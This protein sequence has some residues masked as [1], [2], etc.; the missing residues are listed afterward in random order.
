[1]TTRKTG[2]TEMKPIDSTES[3]WRKENRAAAADS[4]RAVQKAIILRQEKKQPENLRNTEGGKDL[5]IAVVRH[6]RSMLLRYCM[7][8]AHI[9]YFIWSAWFSLSLEHQRSFLI[10]I[11]ELLSSLTTK[12]LHMLYKNKYWWT[13]AVLFGSPLLWKL[14]GR[15]A[16]SFFDK[17]LLWR[18]HRRFSPPE[19]N[20]RAN[21]SR[22]SC[23]E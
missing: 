19:N 10:C 16:M 12:I 21:A 11:M 1:M 9:M 18:Q 6:T 8:Y 4:K 3:K 23:A 22:R 7:T 2:T 5:V 14:S 17:R 20:F 13:E 15:T